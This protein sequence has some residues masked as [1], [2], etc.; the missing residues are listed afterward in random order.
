MPESPASIP[1]SRA[2]PGL[3]LKFPFKHERIIHK[4][5]KQRHFRKFDPNEYRCNHSLLPIDVDM[6]TLIKASILD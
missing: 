3:Y 5:L 6:H 4:I 2:W 1:N